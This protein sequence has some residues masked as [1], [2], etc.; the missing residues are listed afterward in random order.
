M[1]INQDYN[2]EMLGESLR[3]LKDVSPN[4]INFTVGYIDNIATLEIFFS[5][6]LS[7]FFRMD[8]GILKRSVVSNNKVVKYR[9]F[10]NDVAESV[11]QIFTESGFIFCTY[12]CIFDNYYVTL[13]DGK[14]IEKIYILGTNELTACLNRILKGLNFYFK[15]CD[16]L[17]S[18][19]L[20]DTSEG[21]CRLCKTY[22]GGSETALVLK[23]DYS[24][25]IDGSNSS[26]VSKD[27]IRDIISTV[28][29]V[30]NVWCDVNCVSVDL[31]CNTI[32][33]FRESGSVSV[34]LLGSEGVVKS[35]VQEGKIIGTE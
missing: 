26:L 33:V 9:K 12:N 17:L 11:L 27:S 3:A 21:I 24:V 1:R 35:Y 23:E 30:A 15:K 6:E 7:W 8:K 28:N 29:T 14:C 10:A 34:G 4:A 19:R 20:E 25:V 16:E 32:T 2:V 22:R 18:Y 13:K 31:V 5:K